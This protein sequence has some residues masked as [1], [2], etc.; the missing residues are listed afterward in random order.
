MEIQPNSRDYSRLAATLFSRD[1]LSNLT[2]AV[3]GAGALG[4]EVIKNLALLGCGTLWIVDRDSVELSNLTRSI[5]FCTPDIQ[6]HLASKTPKAELAARRARE[7]N[8]DVQAVPFVQEIADLG[9]GTIRR[10]DLVFSCLDNEMA[11][12]ELSWACTRLNKLL[13]DGGLGFINYSS[14]LVSIFPGAEGPCYGCRKGA[15]R[16]RQLLLELYGRED[17]CWLKDRMQEQE[18]IVSTT[19]LMASVVAALQVEFGL[20][21][22]FNRK[23]SSA[24]GCAYRVTLHPEVEL[25]RFFFERSPN[26]PLH[27]P[28][29][30]ALQVREFA[31]Y[32]SDKM[33]PADLLHE[34]GEARSFLCFDWPITARASCRT[35][36]HRWEPLVR[37]ARF[38]NQACPHCGSH[39]LAEVEV[40]TGV[41]HDSSWAKRTFVELGLPRGHVHEVVMESEA[42][43]IH[44]ELTGDLLATSEAVSRC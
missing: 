21:H 44:A 24:A 28:Q 22:F 18:N 3:V 5:L 19:P 4:N 9:S 38:R 39:D 20:R 36:E 17:P 31:H 25:E 37:R 14:G 34:L 11:R 41:A 16:R 8:P 26:C 30:V 7:I 2:V 13:V 10:A 15:E 12:L 43:W 23:P 6:D 32:R 35:C 33:T 1:R 42:Q 27:E 40:L 29:S